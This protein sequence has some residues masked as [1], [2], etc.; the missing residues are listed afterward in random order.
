[1]RRLVFGAAWMRS[2][3]LALVFVLGGAFAADAQQPRHPA[4]DWSTQ[5][6]WATVRIAPCANNVERLCGNIVA[7]RRPND[8]NGQPLR[9]NENPDP[10]PR[11]RPLVGLPFIWDFRSSGRRWTGGHIYDPDSG[12]TYGSNMRVRPD[13]NL[14]VN[15][16]VLFICQA[17]VWTRASP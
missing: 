15:G 10:A 7:L 1:M 17:Q 3:M 5:G 11:A 8:R 13:G 14:E 9:D 2:T 6:G 4:G 12:R 16:C